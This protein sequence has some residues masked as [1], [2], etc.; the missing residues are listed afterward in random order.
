M[1]E[2]R[3]ESS[4]SL[5]RFERD[6][7]QTRD[8]VIGLKQAHATLQ[9]DVNDLRARDLADIRQAYRELSGRFDE[10]KKT[11]WPFFGL[12]VA[13]VPIIWF[14]MNS[15]TQNAIAPLSSDYNGLKTN[16][17]TL[18][19]QAH[20]LTL[21]QET[22]DR[23]I[24]N[25][26]IQ[27]G[28]NST[29]I[30]ALLDQVSTIQQHSATSLEADSASRV[31]RGQINDRVSKLENEM[32]GEIAE[33][34]S[35]NADTKTSLREVETQFCAADQTRNLMHAYDMRVEALLWEK[36]FASRLPTDNAYYP[37]I[38]NPDGTER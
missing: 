20:D 15:L 32:S 9:G 26:N 13:L 31:D 2:L 7:Q 36:S 19:G 4:E 17:T 22:Q 29:T 21:N 8:D 6:F 38:C 1:S 10:S 25:L 24:S 14:M 12:L 34:R 11:N 30:K 37:T 35:Q 23:S 5:R 18:T 28:Q 27:A 33:R 3:G 16:Y